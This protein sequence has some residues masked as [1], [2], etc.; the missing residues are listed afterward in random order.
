MTQYEARLVAIQM[1]SGDDLAANLDAADR[2]IAEAMDSGADLVALP[3]NFAYVGRDDAA[4]LALAEPDG[5]GPIQ[6]FLAEQAQRHGIFLIGGTIALR[7]A[8]PQRARAACLVYSPTGERCA[9]YDKIHLFDVAVGVNERYCESATL[10]G[11]DS[12]VIFDTPFARVGLAVCYDLRFPELFRELVA[13]GA[14]LL[15]VPSAFTALTGAAHWELL[16]RAR[17]VENLCYVIAP[18]QG[19]EHPNGRAT[20]G[21]TLIVDPWGRI[22][23]RC[24]RG[25]GMVHARMARSK[26]EETRRRFPALDHRRLAAVRPPVKSTEERNV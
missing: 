18:D 24:S 11:G 25:P 1:V 19:G 20:Y 6:S 5:S 7:G 21:E 2:L 4:K 23:S 26:L 17:A 8:D 3:E 9:R 13:G 12:V 10:E 16:V 14:E 22:L 15:V